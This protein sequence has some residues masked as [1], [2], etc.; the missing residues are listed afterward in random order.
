MGSVCVSLTHLE[1]SVHY[2]GFHWWNCTRKFVCFRECIHVYRHLIRF[3]GFIILL[4]RE[5]A[6]VR[7]CIMDIWRNWVILWNWSEQVTSFLLTGGYLSRHPL[8]RCISPS[9]CYR[10]FHLSSY[11]IMFTSLSNFIA[12]C[13]CDSENVRAFDR[14][15]VHQGLP[16]RA[17]TCSKAE[18]NWFAPSILLRIPCWVWI[19]YNLC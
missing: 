5:G 11:K 14:S 7:C 3:L 16:C 2:M 15:D 4:I 9:V 13:V 6:D 8:C 12:L 17:E 18:T 10:Y 19:C 1:V